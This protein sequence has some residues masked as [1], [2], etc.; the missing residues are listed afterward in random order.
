MHRV[1]NCST[2][3]L[4]TS[5]MPRPATIAPSILSADFAILANEASR[6]KECGADWLHVDIMDGHFVPNLTIGPPV[7]RSLRRHTD[8]FLDCH[9]MVSEPGMWTEQLAKAGANGATFHLESFC[10][11][12][13]DKDSPVAYSGPTERE[14]D[15]VIAF[16]KKVR[17]LGMATG[18]ALRPLT[19]LSCARRILDSGEIDML[20]VMTVEPGFGGQ[21]FKAEVMDK[22]KEARNAYPSFNIQVDGGLSP[23][24][25]DQAAVAGANI[26]VAGSAVFGADDAAAVIG[27]LRNAVEMA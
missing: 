12:K 13:Y 6:M 4:Y 1:V 20:L 14:T 3:L 5:P 11:A 24:T 18:L 10:E 27:A 22:V 23:K 9:L 16:A 21:K 26:I 17:E 2:R 8:L 25:I 7:V 19:P 15:T